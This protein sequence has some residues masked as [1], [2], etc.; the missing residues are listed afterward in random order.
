MTASR[1]L[2]RVSAVFS[3]GQVLPRGA[4]CAIPSR[5]ARFFQVP[6]RQR[7]ACATTLP[8]VGC[9]AWVEAKCQGRISGCFWKPAAPMPHIAGA[10][11][12]QVLVTKVLAD[13]GLVPAAIA[14][15]VYGRDDTKK[16][17]KKI[18]KYRAALACAATLT[19]AKALQVCVSASAPR[20]SARGVGRQNGI[21]R[22]GHGQQSQKG[23]A[24]NYFSASGGGSGQYRQGRKERA[25]AGTGGTGA[26]QGGGNMAA[27]ACYGAMIVVSLP[28]LG[29][30]LV[31]A[32]EARVRCSSFFVTKYCQYCFQI[33]LYA[34]KM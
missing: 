6:E 22:S 33:L 5:A 28:A 25:G 23:G 10:L 26:G 15:P 8:R 12:G 20:I 18:E 34:T 16:I 1:V 32:C 2:S 29:K 7:G 11:T 27:Y 31:V 3:M 21:V 17:E 30:S 24:R 14:Q 4:A 13:C 19:R 9:A